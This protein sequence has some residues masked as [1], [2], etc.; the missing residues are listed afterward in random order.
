MDT[1]EQYNKYA[2]TKKTKITTN[3]AVVYTRVST[4][5]QSEDNASL[6][7]QLKYCDEYANRKNLNVVEYFGGT[8][9]SAQSDER[10]EFTKMLNFLSRRKNISYIIVYSYDRFSRT[11]ANAAYISSN[12]KK[13]GIHTVSVS[14]EVDTSKPSGA[15]QENLYYMFSEFDNAMRRDKTVTGMREKL[16]NGYWCTNPPVGYINTNKGATADKANLIL[17]DKGKMIKRAFLW[18]YK[19]EWTIERVSIE[20]QKYGLHIKAKRLS[21]LFRNPF[22]AGLLVSSL[23]PDEVIEGKHE[24]A[25][26]PKIFDKVND[27]LNN[28]S[29]SRKGIKI[30][31]KLEDVPLRGL[32]ICDVCSRKMTAYKA[33]KNKEYYYKCNTVGCKNNQRAEQVHESFKE[34]LSYLQVDKKHVEPLK[35]YLKAKFSDLNNENEEKRK[36]LSSSLANVETKLE[37]LE[38]KYL[39][40]GVSQEIYQ[41][42][43]KRLTNEKNEILKDSNNP[44]I[45]LSNLN[46]LIDFS[47]KI[48]SN[49]LKTWDKQDYDKRVEIQNI[50]FPVGIRYNRKKQLYRTDRIN[51]LFSSNTLFSESY[52][53]DKKSGN[54]ILNEKSASVPPTRLELVSRV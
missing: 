6:D 49:L 52:K 11:G 14:Q 41:K 21:E 32:I 35:A 51:T 20:T 29:I 4:K 39:F 37:K 22:Y 5:E 30:Q 13:R 2:K 33:S 17:D 26:T 48:S 47:T 46:K 53:G 54:L 44:E 10:K 9:E 40:E 25:I 15:F 31:K 1:V 34:I 16:R 19:N 50:L 27:I 43:L 3:N 28:K 23:I 38:E 24:R 12:L 42:H 8:Y 7:T 18:I 45:K 36:K